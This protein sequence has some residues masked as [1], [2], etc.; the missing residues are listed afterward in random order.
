M[1][2]TAHVGTPGPFGLPVFTKFVHAA[3]NVSD[4]PV[5]LAFRSRGR[6][7]AGESDVLAYIHPQL[8]AMPLIEQELDVDRMACPG[9]EI[10]LSRTRCIKGIRHLREVVRRSLVGEVP[11]EHCVARIVGGLVFKGFESWA[12]KSSI[13]A[14]PIVCLLSI[15]SV[16]CGRILRQNERAI[17]WGRKCR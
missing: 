17:R 11:P 5:S 1:G 2:N 8:S 15:A 3:T 12:L 16:G 9:L 7:L 4:R 6:L 10:T 14:R 13:R